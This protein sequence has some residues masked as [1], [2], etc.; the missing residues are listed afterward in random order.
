MADQTQQKKQ[1]QIRVPD[2]ALRGHYANIVFVNSSK[3]EF[4]LDFVSANPAQGNGSLVSRIF[5]NP[6]HLKRMIGV[7]SQVMNHYEKSHGVVD[8]SAAPNE[9]EIGFKTE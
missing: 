5:M 1:M 8:A 7:M 4:I 6:S 3:E 9:H 2:D